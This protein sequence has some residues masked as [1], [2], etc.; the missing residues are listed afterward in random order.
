[1]VRPGGGGGM[2]GVGDRLAAN[3][4]SQRLWRTRSAEG[5][6]ARLANGLRVGKSAI[7]QTGKS[8]VRKNRP[9]HEP[10]PRFMAPMCIQFWRSKLPM[11][12]DQ[13]RGFKARHFVWANS[14]PGLLPRGGESSPASQ[15][16]SDSSGRTSGLAKQMRQTPVCRYANSGRGTGPV[17]GGRDGRGWV[18]VCPQERQ[19]TGAL[20]RDATRL[21]ALRL[22]W[23]RNNGLCRPFFKSRPA[24]RLC[25]MA[26]ADGAQWR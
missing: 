21:S 4:P 14:H 17:V 13:V 23:D 8:A 9:L 16:D 12:L 18:G 22:K 7:Q 20:L 26:L 6:R 2:A 11:N 24:P 1:M 15:K 3:P 5:G 19:R 25:K 10:S